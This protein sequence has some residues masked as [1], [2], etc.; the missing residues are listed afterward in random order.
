MYL[1]NISGGLLMRKVFAAIVLVSLLLTAC[2]KVQTPPGNIEITPSPGATAVPGTGD[3]KTPTPTPSPSKAAYD[4]SDFFPANKDVHMVYRGFNNEFAEFETYVEYIR[5]N[6]VQLRNVNPGTSSVIVYEVGNDEL[7]ELYREG[8]IY[9]RHDFTSSRGNSEVLIK[10]PIAVGTEWKLQDG[11]KRSITA[12]DKEISTPNGSFK[13]LEITTEKPGSTEQDYYVKDIGLVKRVFTSKDSKDSISSELEKIETGVPFKHDVRF[14]FPDFLNDRIVYIDRNVEIFTNEDM[15]YKFQKEL[16]TIPEDSGL[17]K[18]LTP[19]VQV[20]STR[21]EK[22]KGLV[23]ADFS[24]HLVDEMNA[25]T[26]LESMLI[27]SI[28]NTY[29]TY[30]G[31]NK[32]IITIEGK[33]Y[34]SGH[35]LMKPGEYFTVDTENTVPY[36]K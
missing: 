19:N 17:T 30:Y 2:T 18:V 8:E 13:A 12:V 23:T 11:V 36:K 4:V 7:K 3:G 24:R 26:S 33:P 21:I 15:K 32:V 27:K 31:V 35:I 5:K 20:S 25:G 1:I 10:E 6:I 16:K 9:Y 22:D 34:S 14:F 29:G 28:V